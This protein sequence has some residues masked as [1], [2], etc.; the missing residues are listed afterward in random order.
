MGYCKFIEFLL[1][2]KLDIRISPLRWIYCFIF[3]LSMA[4]FDIV[5]K[6]DTQSLDNAVNVTKKE[7]LNRYDF[8]DSKT[9]IELDK[10]NS[11]IHLTTENDMRLRAIEDVLL[12][13]VVKQGLD[14]RCL[15]FTEEPYQSG[16]MI[17]KDLKVKEGLEK[18]TAKKIVQIIKENKF[19]VDASIMGDQ[20]RVQAKKIDELQAV[21]ATVR[22]ENFAVPM[23]FVNMKS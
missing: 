1:L 14:G 5:S 19:K 9:I 12:T 4:S 11:L 15:D 23:Q 13:R 2:S 22:R 3:F 17:R 18:E 16:N 20:V 8:R 10:K 7:I 21:I 6:V